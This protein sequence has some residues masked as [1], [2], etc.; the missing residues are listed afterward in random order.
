MTSYPIQK[1]L[2]TYL[3]AVIVLKTFLHTSKQ[4]TGNRNSPS[5]PSSSRPHVGPAALRQH[6]IEFKQTAHWR[7]SISMY[8][9]PRNAYWPHLNK[10]KQG[11]GLKLG[12]QAMPVTLCSTKRIAR[13]L[14]KVRSTSMLPAS[15]VDEAAAPIVRQPRTPSEAAEGLSTMSLICSRCVFSWFCVT[16]NGDALKNLQCQPTL[17]CVGFTDCRVWSF[18]LSVR[19]SSDESSQKW[20]LVCFPTISCRVVRVWEKEVQMLRRSHSLLPRLAALSSGQCSVGAQKTLDGLSKLN[21]DE[22]S[23]SSPALGFSFRGR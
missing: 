6:G 8:V 12:D 16:E 13:A 15:T 19:N 17:Q 5:V 14:P 21:F 23:T 20:V 10:V 18:G 7:S 3:M 4:S 9:V 1:S 11:P 2:S 22:P